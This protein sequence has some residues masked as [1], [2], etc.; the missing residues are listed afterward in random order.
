MYGGMYTCKTL[1]QNTINSLIQVQGGNA[2]RDV[3]CVSWGGGEGVEERQVGGGDLCE[4]P[5]GEWMYLLLRVC[6]PVSVSESECAG[7]HVNR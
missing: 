2:R 4:G 5:E 6:V 1:N 7:W 3:R